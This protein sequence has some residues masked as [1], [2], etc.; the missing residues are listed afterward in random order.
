MNLETYIEHGQDILGSP[1]CW[2]DHIIFSIALA[3]IIWFLIVLEKEII[4]QDVKE[5]LRTTLILLPHIV[6]NLWW[7]IV[8]AEI[9]LRGN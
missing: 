1:N 4:T 9:Y 6:V 3:N 8:F 5:S 7:I 2:V